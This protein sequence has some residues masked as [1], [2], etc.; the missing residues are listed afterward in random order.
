M[1]ALRIIL[2]PIIT[3]KSMNEASKGRYTFKVFS[4]A[5]KN[6]IK[7]AVENKFKVNVLK[8]TTILVKGRRSRRGTRRVEVL[9]QA[10]KKAIVTLKAGQKIALFDTGSQK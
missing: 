8:T 9:N 7:K 6:D 4:S 10:F 5:N 2:R 3:E 1:D